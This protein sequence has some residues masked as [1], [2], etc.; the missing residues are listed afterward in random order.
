MNLKVQP[1]LISKTKVSCK[2][3]R[4]NLTPS[5]TYRS[6]DGLSH[7]LKAARQPL[8]P[9]CGSPLFTPDL[10]VRGRGDAEAPF[11]A[12]STLG[13]PLDQSVL[14]LARRLRANVAL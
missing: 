6:S 13:R 5:A 1:M 14:L 3:V 2:N 12:A 11:L 10:A 7:V 8:S 4:H 9:R